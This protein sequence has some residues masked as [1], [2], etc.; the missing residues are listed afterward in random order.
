MNKF[1]ELAAKM[2]ANRQVM[3]EEADK[4]SAEMD[5]VM[6]QFMAAVDMHRDM[7][8]EAKAGVEAMKEAASGLIGHNSRPNEPKTGEPS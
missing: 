6:P 3:E 4:L 2:K 5:E 7:L 8:G 1:A